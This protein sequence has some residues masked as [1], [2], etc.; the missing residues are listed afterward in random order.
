MENLVIMSKKGRI[1]NINKI[2]VVIPVYNA[3]RTII[4]TLESIVNQSVKPYEVILINDCSTDNTKTVCENFSKKYDYIRV[5]SLLENG[6]VSKARNKGIELANGNYIHFIDSDDTIT[7]DTYLKL[8]KVINEFQY[9][10]VTTGT[11][12]IINNSKHTKRNVKEDIYCKNINE[13]SNYFYRFTADDKERVLNVVW[14]KIYKKSII[15]ENNIEFNEN[16]NLGEDFLFN[17]E[18][19]KKIKNLIEIKDCLYNYYFNQPNN[20]TSKFRTDILSRRKKIYNELVEFYKFYKIYDKKNEK[21]LLKYEGKMMY[22]SLLTVF[23]N[24]CNISKTEKIMFLKDILNDKHVLVVNHYLRFGIEKFFIN[25]KKE[26]SLYN[27]MKL[28]QD[29]KLLLKKI[30]GKK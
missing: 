10:L 9:D 30:G 4:R 3:E 22:Y 29:V 27:Y 1:M 18:Y 20:L 23:S 2:S 5:Y 11:N 6:G 28:K 12:F 8:Y 24:N 13:I 26:K 14:N 25:L 7:E 16:I 21:F 15:I 19:I 17:C